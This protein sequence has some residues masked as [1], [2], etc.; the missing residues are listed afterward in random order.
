MQLLNEIH[1]PLT[2]EVRETRP[3]APTGQIFVMG[4]DVDGRSFFGEARNKKEAKKQCAITILREM[5]KL[6]FP[7]TMA[8]S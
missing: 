7:E 8:T 5:H 3:L 6:E 2:Y 1:G 4:A